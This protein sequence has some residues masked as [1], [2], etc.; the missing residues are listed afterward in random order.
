M[1][2]AHL[3]NGVWMNAQKADNAGKRN[4]LNL[5]LGTF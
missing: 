5:S 2:P 1:Q 3:K 4:N